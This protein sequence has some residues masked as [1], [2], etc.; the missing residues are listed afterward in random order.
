MPTPITSF[1]HAIYK[2]LWTVG[3]SA[4]GA[5]TAVVGGDG[6][7]SLNAPGPPNGIFGVTDYG[8]PLKL[9]VYDATQNPLWVILNASFNPPPPPDYLVAVPGAGMWPA[10]PWPAY[11]PYPL[12][13]QYNNAAPGQR[14]ID[15]LQ[16]WIEQDQQLNDTPGGAHLEF[17]DWSGGPQLV[18]QVKGKE[19]QVLFVC[20]KPGDNGVRPGSID[21]NNY[22][23][24]SQIFVCND[25]GQNIGLPKF[26]AGEQRIIHAIIGNSSSLLAGVINNG[27]PPV[28]VRCNA[29]TW[30]THMS[31]GTPLPEMSALDAPNAG[32]TY[33]QPHL[34]PTSY[35]V[36]GFR[37][38]VDLVFKGL[39]DAIVAAGITP[40]QLGFA[41]VDDYLKANDTHACVKVLVR[42]NEFPNHVNGGFPDDAVA[43]P[44]SDRHIAQRNLAGF[45]M[46][47]VGMKKIKWQTFMMSQAGA[48]AN[49]L[50][51]HQAW[52]TGSK[53]DAA[54]FY[55]ALPPQM[56][57]RYGAKAVHRGFEMVHDAEPKP[58]PDAVILRETAPGARLELLD[59]ARE[60]FFGMALG[61]EGDPARLR[62]A[63]LGDLS[64]VHTAHDGHV[65]G[66]FT[67]RP[68][69]SS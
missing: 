36:A 65:V 8:A 17:A 54:R 34:A 19:E 26:K 41:T 59:H 16:H 51:I 4:G 53:A 57:A 60:R 63:R 12:W 42:A 5:H 67:L 6:N 14:L 44:T 49:G 9:G 13:V 58:F 22:W 62:S 15:R 37:F 29:Y 39:R 24:T 20:S 48:G 64:V 21:P 56:W 30:N 52:S 27:L 23:N 45:D 35:A 7:F 61:V 33:E 55:F 32:V 28:E 18:A 68:Q 10:M 50:A 31:P 1:Y 47:V 66:G 2:R 40:A 38:D 3:V 43:L 46:S 69:L 25:H 11:A